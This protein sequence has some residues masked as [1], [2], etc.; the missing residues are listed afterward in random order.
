MNILLA[1]EWPAEL[2]SIRL[3]VVEA[4]VEN[5]RKNE[6]LWQSMEEDVAQIEAAPE[7]YAIARQPQ[8]QALRRAYKTLGQDPSRY[9]PSAEALRRRALKGKPLFQ[10]NA[11]VDLINKVSLLTGF[12]IGGY[13]AGAIQG[14]V[15]L[16][17]GQPNEPYQALGRKE[18][19]IAR[20]PVLRDKAGA[21]GSPT[22]DSWRTRIEE[23]TRRT[24]LVIFDPARSENLARAMD[25]F[26]QGLVSY[27]GAKAAGMQELTF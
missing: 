20:L 22:S 11:V 21:F 19:N 14:Q 3:G 16:G 6:A 15:R 27:C 25:Y 9:R 10:V 4:E 2:R 26:R 8:I 18:F 23:D 1:D 7:T 5:S 12:S 24:V 13:N 17:A